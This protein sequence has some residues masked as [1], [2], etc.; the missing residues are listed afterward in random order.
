MQEAQL[1][2]LGHVLDGISGVLEVFELHKEES[3]VPGKAL[4]GGG[5]EGDVAQQLRVDF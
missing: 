3:V 2:G 1:C 5:G 4:L